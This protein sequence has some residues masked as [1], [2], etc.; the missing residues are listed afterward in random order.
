MTEVKRSFCRFCIALCGIDVEVDG[1]QVLRVRGVAEDPLSA[2]YTCSKGRALPQFHHHP[3]RLDHPLVRRGETLEAASWDDTMGDLGTRLTEIIERDGPDAVAIYL[4]TG[5]AFDASGR[6][7]AERFIRSIGS[8]SKYTSGSLDTPCKPMLAEMMGG[9]VGLNPTI[10]WEATTMTVLIG[11][12][13]VVSHGHVSPFVDPV[14][15][16]RALA[17]QGEVWVVDPRAT[18]TARLATR[19]LATRPGSDYA[20]LAFAVR[21]LLTEGADAEY[22]AA[23]TDPADVERLRTA[24]A[25]FDAA[26]AAEITG[27][28]V[29]D[30]EDFVAA[31]RRNGRIAGLTGTGVTMAEAANCTEWLLWALL[32]VTGSYDQP[33]GMWFN[34]GYLRQLDQRSWTPGTGDAEPGPTS[35][36]ELPRRLGEY[37]AAALADEIETGRVRALLVVGGNPLAAF[38]EVD[39]LEKALLSLDVLAMVDVV[40]TAT[41]RLATHVLPCAGQLERAD[42]PNYIDQF[43]AVVATRYTA[44]VVPPAGDRRSVWWIMGRL[45]AELGQDILPAGITLDSSDDDL[46][47]QLAARSRAASFEQVVAGGIDNIAPQRQ[48]YGWVLP[49]LPDGKWRIA[50]RPVVE[51]LAVLQPEPG[52]VVVSQRQPHHLNSQLADQERSQPAIELNPAEAADLG[53]AAGTVVTVRSAHGA[54]TGPVEPNPAISRGTCSIPHGFTE[55]NVGHLMSSTQ[56]VDPLSGM[57]TLTGVAVTIEDTG[58]QLSA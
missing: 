32:I 23:Y 47:A 20:L 36:P 4:G 24:V 21:A 44:A 30:L 25:S 26:R 41:T 13:P 49:R 19:H 39:R 16:I 10:D 53:L 8:A 31:I 46:L 11:S 42:L 34:P 51:Q 17:D 7:V 57:V 3:Q 43:Q 56:Q 29:A 52:L 12:N 22:L 9:H 14:R 5:S 37:P 38:P 55:L 48:V 35:R 40:E 15:R 2:G 6:R 27:L 58:V 1:D 54:V 50:P 18:E 33:G 28:E 45:G